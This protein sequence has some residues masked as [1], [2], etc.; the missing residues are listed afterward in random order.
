MKQNYVTKTKLKKHDENKINHLSLL[1]IKISFLTIIG[2]WVK[3]AQDINPID[4]QMDRPFPNGSKKY[5]N[6]FCVRQTDIVQR[7]HIKSCGW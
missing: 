7:E 1:I 3:I 5:D 4:C 6:H 2:Y